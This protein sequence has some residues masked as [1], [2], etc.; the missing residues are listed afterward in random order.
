MTDRDSPATWDRV[1]EYAQTMAR[2][3]TRHSDRRYWKKTAAKAAK[4]AKELRRRA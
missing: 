3:A 4:K 1:E 2:Q